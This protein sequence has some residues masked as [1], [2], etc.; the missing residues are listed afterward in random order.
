MFCRSLLGSELMAPRLTL[1]FSRPELAAGSDRR[2]ADNLAM[3][4]GL[5]RASSLGRR[6]SP[7]DGDEVRTSLAGLGGRADA[8][9]RLHRM[10]AERPAEAAVNL[11]EYLEDISAAIVVALTGDRH[12]RLQLACDPCCFASP[13]RALSIGFIVVELI[14]NAVKYAHPTG[15]AGEIKVA[16]RQGSDGTLTLQVSDDGVGLPEGMDPT[17]VDSL[18]LWLVRSLAAQLGA[19]V[20][21]EHDALGLSCVLQI[22][23]NCADDIMETAGGDGVRR[24]TMTDKNYRCYFTD[25]DDRIRSYEPIACADDT[26][27][28]LKVDEL[29]A[30]SHF[31]SAELWDGKRLV[32]KWPVNG[33]GRTDEVGIAK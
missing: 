27:A 30:G 8:V 4:A 16:C 29:L 18:G 23:G 5:D 2:I 19:R 3:V 1:A 33:N 9:T 25:A 17:R 22:P 15:V 31:S 26:A 21:F 12:I 28:T 20:R 32:G 6:F 24:M 10:L 13:E 7:I 14:T 11:G